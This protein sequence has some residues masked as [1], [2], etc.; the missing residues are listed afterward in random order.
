MLIAAISGA[1]VHPFVVSLDDEMLRKE[2]LALARR[3]LGL[4]T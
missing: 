1:A 3:F 4:T 2:L